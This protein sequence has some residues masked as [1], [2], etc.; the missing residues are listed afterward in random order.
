MLKNMFLKFSA[1]VIKSSHKFHIFAVAN[2][3]GYFCEFFKRFENHIDN[4]QKILIN[5]YATCSYSENY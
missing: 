3:L 4:E 5:C 1:K 2:N